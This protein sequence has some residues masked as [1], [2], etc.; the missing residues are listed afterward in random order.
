MRLFHGVK[1]EAVPVGFT[2]LDNSTFAK[3]LQPEIVDAT[4]LSYP[5]IF[6]FPLEE[7]GAKEARFP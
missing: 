1:G 3:V 7:S 4:C 2:L 6:P 5:A